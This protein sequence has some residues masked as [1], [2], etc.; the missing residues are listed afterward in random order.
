MSDA[1]EVT[2]PTD[3][4]DKQKLGTKVLEVLYQ[5]L[6]LWTQE[7]DSRTDEILE[8]D[9]S[10]LSKEEL[11]TFDNL[12]DLHLDLKRILPVVTY[13]RN[14]STITSDTGGTA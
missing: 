11:D 5:R 14:I 9:I 12:N 6:C 1:P 8:K 10:T 13:A 4:N 3:T 2:K 7:I